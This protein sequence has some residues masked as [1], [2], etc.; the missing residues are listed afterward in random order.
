MAGAVQYLNLALPVND[1]KKNGKRPN[2]L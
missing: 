1:M 2:T